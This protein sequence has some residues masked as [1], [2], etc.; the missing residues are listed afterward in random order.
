MK[1][2]VRTPSRSLKLLQLSAWIR[3]Q[4][5]LQRIYRLVPTPFRRH[6]VG[7]LLAQASEGTRFPRTV[8]W[9]RPAATQAVPITAEP[10]PEAQACSVNIVGYIRGQFGLAEAARSYVR[11]LIG[12][13][14]DV[15]LF[16]LDLGLPHGRED[17][18]L[19]GFIDESLPHDK[20]I[21][22][23]NPD[24]LQQALEQI[25][26]A[27]RDGR[28]LI[29]C[30][31]WELEEV[32]PEWV[33][34]LDLVDEIMVAT[35]FI[36]RALRRVTQ[37]PIIRVPLPLGPMPDS[38]LK[39]A[40]FGLPEE[41]FVFLTSFDFHSW[42]DRKNPYAAIDAFRLAFP[43]GDENVRLLI[44]TSNG[45]CYA[46]KLKFLMESASV[47]PRVLVRDDI[48]DRA[49]F[50]ALQRCS[51]AYV[52]L[53]RA[54]GFGL[55]LA[56]C[57]AMGKP[58]IATAWSGNMEFMDSDTACLVDYHLVE[59]AGGEYPHPPGAVWAQASVADA[60]VAM[61]RLVGDIAWAKALGERARQAALAELSPSLAA[62]RLC[63]RLAQVNNRNSK[64]D[65]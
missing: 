47:D 25:G 40:D 32:P 21:V 6:I 18:S 63:A 38:G 15:R 9:N 64:P 11:A 34:A 52:S 1:N 61:Q 27:R 31:F 23:V 20:T 42:I 30:W 4:G 59:V 54:E 35:G 48:I 56:E 57:M 55:G 49:H 16:D 45:Y 33:P 19:A 60:A 24:F 3:R 5:W 65:A 13:G 22:F 37:K 50:N 29:A 12:A 46:D 41:A 28:Y 14:V 26:G 62:H 39:R 2:K 58:V 10:D 17:D 7:S 44:K 8:A 53:H 51:D 43:R 36:E